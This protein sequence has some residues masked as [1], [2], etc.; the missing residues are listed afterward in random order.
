VDNTPQEIR[1]LTVEMLDRLDSLAT[2]TAEDEL[3]RVE[4]GHLLTGNTTPDTVG[5][6]GRIGR[7]FLR[8]YSSL[9]WESK[10]AGHVDVGTD[11]KASVSEEP[12]RH[13]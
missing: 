10:R 8:T 11:P 6:R 5:T 9:L 4:F 12:L 13:H 2:Y 1:D 3:A 7:E